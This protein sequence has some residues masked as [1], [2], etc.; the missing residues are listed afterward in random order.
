MRT[1]ISAVLALLSVPAMAQQNGLPEGLGS[2]ALTGFVVGYRASNEKQFL[3]EEIPEGETVHSWTRMVTTQRYRDL[4]LGV[5]PYQMLQT[6]AANAPKS[7]PR[8]VVTAPAS[9]TIGGRPAAQMKVDC[10]LNPESGTPETF[11]MLAVAGQRDMMI[12]QVAFRRLPSQ[13]DIAFATGFLGSMTVCTS[14]DPSSCK[15]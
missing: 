1:I 5:T 6:V 8:A 15:R 2:P 4:A 12:K 7:C 9:L 3:Q 14:T 13:E 10:P 11:F